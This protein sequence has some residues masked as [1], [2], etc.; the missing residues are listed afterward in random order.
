M[1]I[2]VL[3]LLIFGL[4]ASPNKA[5]HGEACPDA[6]PSRLRVGEHAEV[7][8][9]V[10]RLNLRML[11]AVG[12]GEVRLLYAGTTFEV[13][14]GPSCNG[15]FS[16]WRVALQDGSKGWVAEGTWSAYYLRPVDRRLCTSPEDPWLQWVASRVCGLLGIDH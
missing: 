8:A 4:F 11:P 16:W 13:L 7:A 9:G 12:T 1:R 3:I 14:A 10:D 5:S 6:P 15:G 2:F